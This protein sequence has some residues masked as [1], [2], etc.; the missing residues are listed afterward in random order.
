PAASAPRSARR[1]ASLRLAGV[2]DRTAVQV[3]ETSLREGA[4]LR[5]TPPTTTAIKPPCSLA[6]VGLRV[7]AGVP[8]GASPQTS[9]RNA[10]QGRDGSVVTPL[11]RRRPSSRCLIA[12]PAERCNG[13][14]PATPA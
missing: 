2:P 1:Q 9:D 11:S 5:A 12:T 7:R 4:R 8:H 10:R 14:R 6:S 13:G 3:F